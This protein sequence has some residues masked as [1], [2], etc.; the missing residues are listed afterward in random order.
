MLKDLPG[1]ST[2]GLGNASRPVIR[3]MKNSRVKIQPIRKHLFFA[4]IVKISVENDGLNLFKC[5]FLCIP[6]C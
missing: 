1:V 5:K 2:N 4:V 3:G 6:H